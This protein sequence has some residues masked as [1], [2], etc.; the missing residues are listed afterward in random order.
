VLER[1]FDSGTLARRREAVLGYAI[2][3]GMPEARAIDVMIAVH[4]LAA[5]AVRHGPG[6]GR[7][8]MHATASTLRG[9]VSDP[10]LASRN[11]HAADGAGDPATA[12]W[13][14]EQGHG[15]WLAR[16]AADDLHVTS[17]PHGTVIALAFTLPVPAAE[18]H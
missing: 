5:N 2:A 15:L 4:E 6:Y 1:E 10:G 16:K 17:G 12:P 13:P 8:R 7:L 18:G 14:F 9:E 3:C 11:G